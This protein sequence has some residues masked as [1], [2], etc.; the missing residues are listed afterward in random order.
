MNTIAGTVYNVLPEGLK[1]K[2]QWVLWKYE[3]VKGRKTKIPYSVSGKRA[4]TTDPATWATFEEACKKFHDHAGRFDGIG[5]VF[6]DDSEYMGVDLDH[7]KNP[8]TGEW[9]PEAL[10]EIRSLNTYTEISPSGTGA[11]C[12]CIA[13]FPGEEK[14]KRKGHREMYESKRYFTMTGDRMPDTPAEIRPAQKAVNRLYKKWFEAEKEETPKPEPR[15]EIKR[16]SKGLSDSEIIEMCKKA[17]NSGTFGNLYSG[18]WEGSYPSQSEADLSL[19][20]ILAFYTQDPGQIDRIFSG[21]GLYRDKWNRADYKNRTIQE[22]LNGL[23][24]TYDPEK[25]RRAN[26]EESPQKGRKQTGKDNPIGKEKDPFS[27]DVDELDQPEEV[28]KAAEEEARLILAE[29]DPIRYILD[30]IKEKHTGDENM[31]EGI[32]V[33]IAGQSCL[34]TAGLQISVN[35]ESGS[36]KSHGLKSHLHLVP[37]AYKRETSLSA[38]AAYYMGLEPGLILF[39]DDKDPD[40]AS[41]E[42]I[43]RA[44]T[45]YQEYT[46]H[47]T[48]KD[49]KTQTVT[50]PPRINWY[51]TS[52][53]SNVS[54]QLLN[55]QLTFSTDSGEEQKKA[56]FEI[57]QAEA[58]AGEIFMLEVTP[59][60]LTCRRI[61]SD[62]KNGLFKVK[63]PF[64]DRIEIRD[65]SNS[66]IFPMFLDMIKGYTIFKY[67]QREKDPDGYILADLED[68]ER[69]KRLFESQRESLVSKLTDRE[70]LII[71]FIASHPRCNINDIA[72]GTKQAYKTVHNTLMGRKDRT[73]GGMLDKCKGLTMTDQ[74]TS[75]EE[76]EGLRVGRRAKVFY[77]ENIDLWTLFDKE[78]ITL[79]PE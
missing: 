72:R 1:N 8:E 45:N 31:Q 58:L 16:T 37:R 56:I 38:K 42:V 4:D 69:A 44:T 78:F 6:S 46:I 7:V 68:F 75:T 79:K 23:T 11:H 66:R 54:D 26:R 30:T 14:G 60:V 21:S 64:A 77:I 41:E 2:N 5:F 12:I 40:E 22:A 43:K 29:G 25:M 65:K 73:N 18:L 51:L 53:E 36:G 27:V 62:I 13:E 39:S 48:V 67:Q 50:I 52:V 32:A 10:E 28:I 70:R 33:S 47:T 9:D 71:Q 20:S 24:G 34:N 76:E 35:G 74:T 17:K 57:Q 19:C 63:I 59:E 3:E 55:R 15:E 61:Y 49:Q